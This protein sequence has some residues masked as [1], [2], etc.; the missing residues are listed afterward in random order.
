MIHSVEYQRCFSPCRKL[1]V[2]I[3]SNKSGSL[4]FVNFQN[5]FSFFAALQNNA[6]SKL[7]FHRNLFVLLCFWWY[8]DVWILL[9]IYLSQPTFSL[10]VSIWIDFSNWIWIFSERSRYIN[11]ASKF[12]KFLITAIFRNEVLDLL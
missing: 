7:F 11:T 10:Y 9:G 1:I 3:W 4:N 2:H 12:L 8:V 5:L 6:D